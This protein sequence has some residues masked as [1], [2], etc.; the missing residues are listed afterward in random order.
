[1]LKTEKTTPPIKFS[2]WNPG[3]SSLEGS[4][5]SGP[6][7]TTHSSCHLVSFSNI[8]RLCGQSHRHA[9]VQTCRIGVR[10]LCCSCCPPLQAPVPP[11]RNPT[12]V[13]GSTSCAR[14]Q[15]PFPEPVTRLPSMQKSL[16]KAPKHYLHLFLQ[17]TLKQKMKLEKYS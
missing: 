2:S 4:L 15:R 17:S 9:E 10:H 13:K 8:R 16:L 7:P 12:L 1:M 3:V 5:K 6:S 11:P 14:P